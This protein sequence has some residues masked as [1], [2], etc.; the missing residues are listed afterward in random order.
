MMEPCISPRPTAVRLSLKSL[1]A[2]ADMTV[3]GVR[4]SAD[5]TSALWK[6]LA[7]ELSY[8]D[9]EVILELDARDIDIVKS[10][11]CLKPL[12]E[13]ISLMPHN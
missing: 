3:Q 8:H 10:I 5:C 7:V 9:P 2:E 12:Q 6:N 11:R 4:V 13:R 1:E